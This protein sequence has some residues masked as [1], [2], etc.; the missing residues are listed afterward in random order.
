MVADAANV[1]RLAVESKTLSNS[2]NRLPFMLLLPEKVPAVR[3]RC[4]RATKTSVKSEIEKTNVTPRMEKTR[5]RKLPV[6]VR[7]L[8]PSGTMRRQDSAVE[9]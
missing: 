3:S 4:K 5:K 7:S 9:E 2:L 8:F 6:V 1:F